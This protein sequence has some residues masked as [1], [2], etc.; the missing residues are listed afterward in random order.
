MHHKAGSLLA[1]PG[2]KPAFLQLF[3]F[4][5]D[6][7]ENLR[8]EAFSGRD[9]KL[10]RAIAEVIQTVNPFAR[11]LQTN[12]QTL[13]ENPAAT[14]RINLLNIDTTD[15]RRYNKPVNESITTIIPNAAEGAQYR[16]LILHRQDGSRTRIKETSPFYF[17]FR[18]TIIFPRRERS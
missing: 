1:V 11:F 9:R 14:V 5:I 10:S 8:A 2:V 3:I 6:N 13:R 17:T 16:N 15:K 4:T 18:Y 7:Q 12:A